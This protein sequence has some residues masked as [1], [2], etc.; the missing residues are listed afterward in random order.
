M[1]KADFNVDKADLL[2]ITFYGNACNVFLRLQ[3]DLYLK[4][5]NLLVIASLFLYMLLSLPPLQVL[6]LSASLFW[7]E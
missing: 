2:R 1:D 6:Q 3:V 4:G 7:M 5:Y